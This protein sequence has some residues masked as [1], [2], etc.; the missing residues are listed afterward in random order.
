MLTKDRKERLGQSGD[1]EEIM[2]HPFFA[3]LNTAELLNKQIP[4]PYVPAIQNQADIANFDSE[5]T[6]QGLGESIIPA[7]DKALVKNKKDAF[8]GFGPI[9]ETLDG[10]RTE[11][12]GTRVSAEEEKKALE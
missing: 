3:D 7:A 6:N 11:G 4:A 9:V 12:D 10:S 5:V 8:Q 2:S 1:V